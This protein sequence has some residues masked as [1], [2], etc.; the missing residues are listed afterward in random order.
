MVS[1]STSATTTTPSFSIPI[2]EKLSKTNFLVW[3]L[4][5]LPAI[6]AAQLRGHPYWR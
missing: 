2:T 3:R 1:N 6:R 4:Q 5:I